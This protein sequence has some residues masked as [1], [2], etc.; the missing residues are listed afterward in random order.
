M[1]YIPKELAREIRG[2]SELIGNLYSSE[3]LSKC[4]SIRKKMIEK[5]AQVHS[6]KMEHPY[7]EIP[8]SI[9]R[10]KN[11]RDIKKGIAN[12]R[13]AFRWGR[14]NFSSNN[15]EE[16]F[17]REI[18][19]RITPEFYTTNIARYRDTG[20]RIVGATTTPPYPYKLKEKEIPNFVNSMKKQLTCEDVINRV[21]TAIYAHLHIV[22]MHPFVDGNGRTARTLQDIILDHF[23]IP[24]P[25]IKAGERNLYYQ[26]LDE[27]I[28]DWKKKKGSGEVKNGA[29]KG[30]YLFYN[31]IAG[32]V[33]VSY[34]KLIEKC[35]L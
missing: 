3:S 13:N 4:H 26:I 9:P 28:S 2:K 23:D 35:G 24:P 19:G 5:N 10:N 15:F 32:K 7:V 34:D 18:A 29:T 8:F 21:E 27:A 33:N 1:K 6:Y 14:K 16:S 25:I 12:I 20:T 30:E 11:R 22:R 31:F 17:V